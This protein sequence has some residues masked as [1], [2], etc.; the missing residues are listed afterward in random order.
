MLLLVLGVVAAGCAKRPATTSVAAPPPSAPAPAAPPATPAPAPSTPAPAA[1]VP[2]TPSTPAPAPAPAAT[3]AR[4]APA[5]FASIPEL[6]DIHFD[7]DKYD[8]RPDA[9]RTLDANAAWL[10]SNGNQLLLIEGHCDERG[11]NEY[12]LALGE[13]RA[14]SAMNYL[15]S[16]G[17]QASRI[18][19]ISYGEERP[20][21]T[22]HT[23][24]CWAQNRRDH[25]LVKPR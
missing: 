4:P 15:V 11:T 14:K 19:I 13:R 1:P 8:I 25:F 3:T 17:V 9:A 23:E 24:T 5:E 10:K 12:N 6:K 16:Q 21:C 7:F 2:S 20:L 18:T 22:E